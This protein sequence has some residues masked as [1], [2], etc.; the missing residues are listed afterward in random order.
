MSNRKKLWSGRFSESASESLEDFWNSIGF[1]QRLAAFDIRG[2]I[3]HARMLGAQGIISAEESTALIA[4]LEGLAADLAEGKIEF[5]RGDEDIHMNIERLLHERIG[6]AAGKLHTARSRNDQ[7]A[8]DMHMFAREACAETARLLLG[9]QKALLKLAAEQGDAVMPGYTHLQRAQPVLFGH[10]LLAYVWMFQRDIGRMQDCRKR[11]NISPLGAGALA[12]TT[13]PIDR[14]ATAR[15]LGF[16]GIY[17]NSLDAVSDRDFA[18]ELLA[19]NALVAAHLS[20]F[21]E[22]IILWMT[23]EFGFIALGDSYCTGSSMMPQKKNPDLAEL[24]RGKTGRIYGALIAMLTVLKG[25]PLAYNK[26]FQEDKEG[27]FDSVDTVQKSLFHLTG[28]LATLRV[29]RDAMHAAA[30]KGFLNA[31]DVADYLAARNVPFRAA[32]E[33]AGKLV[34]LCLDAGK[35]LHELTLPELQKFSAAFADDVYAAMDLNNVVGRRT[36]AGG[37]APAQV[38]MQTNQAEIAVA[39]TESWLKTVAP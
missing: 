4:G 3:A 19:A 30:S 8:L 13:F 32:H 1:D 2:S 17:P 28:M 22:E 35:E 24:V 12:G 39:E 23:G 21:C 20:R 14:E 37:T 18:V 36:S 33:I 31:T 10:H 27:L 26:D 6:P 7:V 25:T 15:E 34:R 16:E 9:M 29:K 38:A 5:A 11:A